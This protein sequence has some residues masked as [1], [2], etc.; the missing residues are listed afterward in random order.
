MS[1]H[2]SGRVSLDEWDSDGSLFFRGGEDESAEGGLEDEADVVGVVRWGSHCEESTKAGITSIS[3]Q[4]PNFYTFSA[5][6]GWLSEPLV[7]G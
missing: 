6:I 2:G 1:T 3:D 5:D 7:A 4:S